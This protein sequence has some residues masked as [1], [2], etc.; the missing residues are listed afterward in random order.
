MKI[1]WIRGCT[2]SGGVGVISHCVVALVQQ[3][4]DVSLQT[5]YVPEELGK[6]FLVWPVPVLSSV[7]CCELRH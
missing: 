7:G 5:A 2:F 6:A 1:S 4:S 3:S